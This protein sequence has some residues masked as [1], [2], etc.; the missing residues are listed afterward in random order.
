VVQHSYEEK[1]VH[2]RWSTIVIVWLTLAL[3]AC[4]LGGMP[5]DGPPIPVTQEAADRFH[6]KAA[7]AGSELAANGAASN[8]VT[9]EEI[10][11][12]VALGLTEAAATSPTGGF[13]LT[14]PQIYF[15]QDGS[16][17]VRG[18]IGFQGRTQPVRIVAQPRV[19]SDSLQLNIVGGQVGRVP[20]PGPILNQVEGALSR[21]ILAGQDYGRVTVVQVEQGALTIAGQRQ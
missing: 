5:D 21:A 17:A 18:N 12:A 1:S 2:R 13:P 8:T 6:Q 9:Q 11:S 20:V 4:N 19:E 10:T 3:S 14:E 7:A 15:K 16:I